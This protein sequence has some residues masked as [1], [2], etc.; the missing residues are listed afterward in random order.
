MSLLA[1]TLA[2]AVAS[3]LGGRRD[4][5]LAPAPAPAAS[6]LE[7]VDLASL[8]LVALVYEPDARAVVE[9]GTGAAHVVRPGTPIGRDGGQVIAIE[10][11][12]L[13][14]REPGRRDDLRLDLAAPA[15]EPAP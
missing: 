5:F 7:R 15:A 9:D 1:F 12:G 8:R 2:L 4:L 3:A 6:P 14:I 11:G 13:R 10:R